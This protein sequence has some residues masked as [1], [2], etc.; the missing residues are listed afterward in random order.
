MD[1]GLFRSIYLNHPTEDEL[2]I[3][4]NEFESGLH[5]AALHA[6]ARI[7]LEGHDPLAVS[8]PF[9]KIES[10]DA[11][12]YG[13]LATPTDI[14]DGQGDF[15]SVQFVIHETM[16]V[17]VLW[18]TEGN[19]VERSNDIYHQISAVESASNT[20]RTTNA[21]DPGDVI[22]R[23]SR[24]IVKDLQSLLASL[25][26]EVKAELVEI[27][28]AL[29]SREYQSLSLK[30]SNK[31]QRIS[32]LKFEI[33]SIS[34]TI[35]ETQNVFKAIVEGTVVIRPPFVSRE[36]DV[37]PFSKSQR[38]WFQDLLMLTRS[39]KSQRAGLEGEVRLLYERLESLENRLQTAAQMRFAAVA[40]ILL[41]PALLVGF[42]GQNFNINPWVESR[43]SWEISAICLGGI[44][45]T[46]WIYFKRKKWF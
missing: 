5:G 32:R 3:A 45:M 39:L 18:G 21:D 16:A 42:F 34:S 13:V 19:K 10:H 23:L 12:L 17:V 25:H 22:V 40:S 35:A 6:T 9:P 28:S 31:Y 30:A 37:A 4:L 14:E 20:L 8:E 1:T 7:G 11:Y 33:L 46:Q 26:S 15:F 24:V 44:A 41:F 29:F 27:E 2:R 36:F 43:W 38:I